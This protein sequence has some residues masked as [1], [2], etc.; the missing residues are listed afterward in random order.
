MELRVVW[1]L[2]FDWLIGRMRE[3]GGGWVG[4]GS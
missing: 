4:R 3:E 1:E 2:G